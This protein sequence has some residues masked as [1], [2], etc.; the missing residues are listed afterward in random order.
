MRR[1]PDDEEVMPG[2]WELPQATG[3]RALDELRELGVDPSVK[4]GAFKHAITYR[5]FEGSV[6]RAELA[7]P[8]PE[9]Y[10]WVTRTRLAALPVSTITKK[11]LRAAG[12]D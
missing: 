1:R 4:I 10:R 12:L 9:E 11:A 3:H 2:F 7:G 6:Y 5:A 8:R